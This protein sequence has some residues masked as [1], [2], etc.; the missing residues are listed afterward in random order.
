M[1]NRPTCPVAL[2]RTLESGN[3]VNVSCSVKKK[4]V[5]CVQVTW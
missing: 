2:A 3:V 5:C 4:V 1:E